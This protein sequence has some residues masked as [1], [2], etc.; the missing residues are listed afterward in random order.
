MGTLSD[1]VENNKGKW[2][3]KWLPYLEVYERHFAR[4]RD[5][6]VHVLE[7]GVFGGGSLTMW[8]HYFGARAQIFGVD[9]DPVCK[10]F[11]EERAKIFIGDQ[12]DRS[13]LASLRKSLPRIDILID[14]GGHYPAQQI[15]T[16]EELFPDIAAD[17][18]YLCE[19]LHTNYWQRYGGGLRR[20]G[21]FMEYAKR[22]VD[23]L[24]AWHT[25]DAEVF[26]VD[27]FTLT[28]HS[29]HFYDS[30]V[31]IEKRPMAPPLRKKTGALG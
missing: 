18:I 6:D 9:I 20:P 27:D 15:A 26:E 5:T 13:F 12:G 21:T 17:G 25:E 14:D 23:Q 7:I 19:D 28:A 24:T 16:F 3:D 10:Q 22:L 31:V 30:M 2:L 1:Y 29:M 4:Y 8:K 11:E